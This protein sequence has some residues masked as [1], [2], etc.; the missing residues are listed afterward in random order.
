MQ[1]LKKT[2][3]QMFQ[4]LLHHETPNYLQNS[5]RLG[6]YSRGYFLRILDCMKSDFKLLHWVLGEEL[7][8]TSVA[9]YIRKFPLR[10]YNI[11]FIGENF[12]AYFEKNPMEEHSYLKS[13]A[14][15]ELNPYYCFNHFHEKPFDMKSLES[16]P[17]EAWQNAMFTFQPHLL[18]QESNWDLELLKEKFKT[19]ASFEKKWIIEKPSY[20]LFYQKD[21]ITFISNKKPPEFRTLQLLMSGKT[22]G[23]VADELEHEDISSSIFEWFQSWSAQEFIIN[24]SFQET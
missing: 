5:E 22:L 16:V 2:Q 23:E 18:L 21:E 11:N 14:E 4:D 13:L 24:I 19:K 12:P 1:E 8:K 10:N 17:L 20:Y 15:F 6:L 7:F 3:E 9:E